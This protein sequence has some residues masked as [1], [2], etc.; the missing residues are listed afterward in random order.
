MINK[1]TKGECFTNQI[2]KD[3]H[4]K[5]KILTK[6]QDGWSCS[7]CQRIEENSRKGFNPLRVVE[8]HD[9]QF[10]ITY[11]NREGFQQFR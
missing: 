9:D 6:G 4:V 7:R 3:L 8:K 10:D 1:K 11:K 2:L 5:F